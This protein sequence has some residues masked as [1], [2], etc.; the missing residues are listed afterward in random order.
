M[1]SYHKEMLAKDHIRD[2]MQEAERQRMVRQAAVDKPDRR[3]WRPPLAFASA[4]VRRLGR[5][6]H[7]A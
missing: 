3:P 4:L 2:L 5:V 6:A 7:A 1:M